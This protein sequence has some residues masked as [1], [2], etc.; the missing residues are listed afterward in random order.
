MLDIV[1]NNNICDI[2]RIEVQRW[3]AD[4]ITKTAN[5]LITKVMLND[6]DTVKRRDAQKYIENTY[7][8]FSSTEDK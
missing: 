4:I 3:K 7:D 1:Q 2:F 5:K 8:I 6:I